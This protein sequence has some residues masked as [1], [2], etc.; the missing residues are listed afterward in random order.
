MVRRAT[1][2]TFM[3]D[4][5]AVDM[6]KEIGMDKLL[7]SSDYPHQ[8]STWPKSQ[9]MIEYVTAGISCK[10]ENATHHRRQRGGAL[11]LHTDAAA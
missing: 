5:S 3:R 11:R 7:W 6:R 9:Q 8:D 10:L 1:Y 2:L 4:K